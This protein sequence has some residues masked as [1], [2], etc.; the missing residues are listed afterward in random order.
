MLYRHSSI[1]QAAVFGIPNTVLGELVCAAV[2]LL[3]DKETTVQQLIDWCSKGL[4]HYKVPSSIH[5]LD[6]LPTTG[7]GK[8]LKTELRDR[9]KDIPLTRPQAT[10]GQTEGDLVT[11][12]ERIKQ[13]L[14][15]EEIKNIGKGRND[16]DPEAC[17]ILMHAD[18]DLV[19]Q[20]CTNL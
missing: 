14:Y 13:I 16:L 18:G 15:L 20:V 6:K 3:G 5:I 2:V 1:H 17:H 8:I 19:D 10:K 11:I 7:S 9:F 12:A 4:A